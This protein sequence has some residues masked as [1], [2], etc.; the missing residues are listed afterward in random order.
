MQS[1]SRKNNVNLNQRWRTL[2]AAENDEVPEA[3]WWLGGLLLAL[4]L[5]FSLWNFENYDTRN[6]LVPW[7][8]AIVNNGRWRS[9]GLGFSNYTPPYLYLLTLV[10]YLPFSALHTVKFVSFL[11]DF[12]LAFY[13]M[14]LVG[15]R[16]ENHTARLAPRKIS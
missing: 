13:V 14:R 11:F 7:Y 10:S 16:Y 15:L 3:V 6:F 8:N 4:L 9:F 2:W 12:P 1:E 5:R